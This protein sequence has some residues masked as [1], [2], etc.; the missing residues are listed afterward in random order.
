[1]QATGPDSIGASLVFLNLLKS[2]TDRFPELFL[3]QTKHV[4][5]QAHARAD[6][7]V[8]RVRLVAP[9]ATGPSGL[10]VH[11]HLWSIAL[12]KSSR[13]NRQFTPS[14]AI[15]NRSTRKISNFCATQVL[16]QRVLGIAARPSA[17]PECDGEGA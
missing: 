1:M 10:L 14:Y 4:T 17:Q 12:A 8:D 11:R 13:L 16:A 5:A 2:Q 3:A 6:V 15:N 9:L 7:N